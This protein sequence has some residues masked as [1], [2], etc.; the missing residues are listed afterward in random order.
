[1]RKLLV[2]SFLLAITACGNGPASPTPGGDVSLVVNINHALF[3]DDAVLEISLW[4]AS[5]LAILAANARCGTAQGSGGGPQV[6]CPPGVTYMDVVPEQLNFPLSM[7]GATLEV[8]PQ[9]IAPGEMFRI[10]LS[11]LSRD[12]C[13]ATSADLVRMAAAGQMLLGDPAWQTTLLGCI[14]P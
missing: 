12:R 5:Q 9:H 4:N 13:N 14:S 2:S 11:G 10:H 7:I 6:Q 8:T 1:M 3:A